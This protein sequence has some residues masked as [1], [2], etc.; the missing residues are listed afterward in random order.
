MDTRRAI[1]YILIL[2][3]IVAGGIVLWAVK[4]RARVDRREAQRPIRITR[5]KRPDD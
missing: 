1:A 5:K 3:L 2:A 4:R